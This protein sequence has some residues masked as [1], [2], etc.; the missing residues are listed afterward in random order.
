MSDRYLVT[1]A[2]GFVGANLVRELVRQKKHVSVIVRDRR[3]NFRLSDIASKL[4]IYE[5]DL[6]KPLN[7]II[8]KIKPTIIYHLAAYGVPTNQSDV[9]LMIDI[10][11]KGTLNLINAVK[12]HPFK[13]FV[14]TGTFSEYELKEL[15]MKETDVLK[16]INDYGVT[17]AA[18][19]LFAQKMAIRE[20]LPIITLRLFYAYGYYEINRFV[21]NVILAAF[22]NR[23][24]KASQPTFVRDFIHV[25]D[26]VDAY[27][28]A[29]DSNI[30]PGSIFNIGSGQQHT[31]KEAADI[32]IKLTRSRSKILWGAF[33]TDRHV[34]S[35]KIE[36]DISLAKEIL[37][38]KPIYALNDGLK[39]TVD[40]FRSH[41]HLYEQ[42]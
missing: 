37:K 8:D 39:K 28:K 21:P 9:N 35:N 12:R 36:A 23:E 17:K 26:I 42:C 1:G 13:L 3:L 34:E 2:T 30:T 40:W 25:E 7:S 14:N 5:G 6:R 18:A 32:I 31:L 24:I 20:S 16:P 19:T 38:W 11:I 10:N 22:K 29:K 27:I 4:Y 41:I 33:H 15:P